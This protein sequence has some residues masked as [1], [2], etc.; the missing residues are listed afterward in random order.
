MANYNKY[1]DTRRFVV[2]VRGPTRM[3]TRDVSARTW[4]EMALFLGLYL[5]K[6]WHVWAFFNA[7]VNLNT[8]FYS[9]FQKYFILKSLSV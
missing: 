5:V 6:T 8:V 4:G 1:G 9:T 2:R 3:R 7:H